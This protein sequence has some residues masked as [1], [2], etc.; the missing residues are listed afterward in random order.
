MTRLHGKNAVLYMSINSGDAPTEVPFISNF[1]ESL[2]T[3]KAEA[4]AYGD[5]NKVKL[6][7]LPERS[8]TFDGFYDDS[9]VQMY[10]AAIDGLARTFYHYK[11]RNAMESDYTFGTAFFDVTVTTPVG[12]AV[13][14]SGNWDAAGDITSV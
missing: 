5:R 4:T 1:V 11:N 13:S 10:T 2:A 12:D 14:I 6:A 9:T 3:D 7:G 8:G